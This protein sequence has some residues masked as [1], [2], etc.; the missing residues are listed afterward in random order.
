MI[1]AVMKSASP[2]RTPIIMHTTS[3][4]FLLSSIFAYKL[5]QAMVVSENQVYP[6]DVELG[7]VMKIGT[8][9]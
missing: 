5:Y 7:L 1:M 2:K 6:I 8:S 9:K 3:V 4:I